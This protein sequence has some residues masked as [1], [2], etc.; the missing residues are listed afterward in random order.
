MTTDD[1]DTQDR[2]DLDWVHLS[3]DPREA[4][5]QL[6]DVALDGFATG[7][8]SAFASS[9]MK[10]FGRDL[11]PAKLH[12]VQMHGR[13]LSR[14]AVHDPAVSSAIEQM[15]RCRLAGHTDQ[16]SHPPVPMSGR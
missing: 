1:H 6:I 7:I 12:R 11:T 8:V 14:H 15:I 5:T 2:P 3:D 16:C 13:R 10:E 9:L 4:L